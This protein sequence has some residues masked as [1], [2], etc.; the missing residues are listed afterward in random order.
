MQWECFCWNM[1]L[2]ACLPQKYRQ[3]MA[4][5]LYQYY[6][7]LY[8]EKYFGFTRLFHFKTAVYSKLEST[9]NMKR[10]CAKFCHIVYDCRSIGIIVLSLSQQRSNTIPMMIHVAVVSFSTLK[11]KKEPKDNA[12][13][14]K[15]SYRNTKTIRYKVDFQCM[16][17]IAEVK[18]VIST[19]EKKKC[20][21]F[22]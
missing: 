18:R 12:K 20:K 11:M 17:D 1:F 13:S 4:W 3:P 22:I 15:N 9:G 2:F 7:I 21:K 6:A 16:C 8:C 5:L 14:A 19:S 10:F